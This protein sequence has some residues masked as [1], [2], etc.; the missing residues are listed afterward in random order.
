MVL[1]IGLTRVG[2]EVLINP[3]DSGDF[4]NRL[5]PG[6]LMIRMDPL[7]VMHCLDVRSRGLRPGPLTDGDFCAGSYT[8]EAL[9][10]IPE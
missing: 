6:L 2:S 7:D 4:L 3:V 8:S 5:T 9:A 1:L 10:L